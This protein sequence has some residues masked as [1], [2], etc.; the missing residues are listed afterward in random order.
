M[1]LARDGIQC[2]EEADATFH[3]DAQRALA[4]NLYDAMHTYGTQLFLTTHSEEFLQ[5]L[6]N[7]MKRR[8][9]AFLR[10]GVRV[11]TLRDIGGTVRQRTLSGDEAWRALADGLELRR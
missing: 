5:M 9:T 10:D 6:L 8:D 11:I 1:A 7:E 2:I 3:H 4:R